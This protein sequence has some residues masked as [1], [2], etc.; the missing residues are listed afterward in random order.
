MKLPRPGDCGCSDGIT[1]GDCCSS[2]EAVTSAWWGFRVALS[3]QTGI[4]V[5]GQTG[6][7]EN[8]DELGYPG[9]LDRPHHED[10]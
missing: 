6:E 7:E 8:G 1:V 9:V 2:L 5:K 4:W 3:K 10:C